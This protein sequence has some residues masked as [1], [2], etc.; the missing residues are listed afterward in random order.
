MTEP[1]TQPQPQP[2]R[3]WELAQLGVVGP[4]GVCEAA[5][6]QPWLG[7]LV[8]AE[9][10]LSAAAV[11]AAAA[12]VVMVTAPHGWVAALPTPTTAETTTT[13]PNT[14]P[15]TKATESQSWTT[16]AEVVQK[17]LD[18]QTGVLNALIVG[19]ERSSV[20]AGVGALGTSA[21]HAGVGA[22]ASIFNEAHRERGP[23]ETGVRAAVGV[24][25]AV[26]GVIALGGTFPLLT[27]ALAVVGG[28]Q[29]VCEV[30]EAMGHIEA[31][32]DPDDAF[33]RYKDLYP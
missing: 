17:A 14:A 9:P 8:L 22:A 10:T 24:A 6:Q 4:L 27:G 31:E 32:R 12:G 30:V 2:Q 3:G 13:T 7:P 25:T 21:A 19:T 20:A 1:T 23:I 28:A 33:T 29:V 16:G 5:A 26:G 18:A 11:A 15:T